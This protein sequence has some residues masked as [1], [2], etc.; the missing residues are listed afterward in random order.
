[1]TSLIP[2]LL[3]FALPLAAS[4]AEEQEAVILRDGTPLNPQQ[5]LDAQ[6]AGVKDPARIR[7][8]KVDAIPTPT[9]PALA[10]ANEYVGMINAQS[11]SVTYG[12]GVFLRQDVADNRAALVHEL[13]HVGQYERLGN[14]T[15]FLKAYLQECLTVGHAHS[16]LEREAI[17]G[18]RKICG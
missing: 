13:V 9:Q 18:T 7:V 14:I 11:T 10:K 2:S 6:Q 1:M 16:P 15:E 3:D 5:V 12:Y 4:Y 8:L 17:D